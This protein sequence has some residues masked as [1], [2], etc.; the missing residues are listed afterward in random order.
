MQIEKS[1]TFLSENQVKLCCSK[2]CPVLTL[3]G[4]KVVITDDFGGAITL[5]KNESLF[6]SEA[7]EKLLN[8][9]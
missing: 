7:A 4:D 1:I 2:G 3:V 5:T 6:L 9:D 8:H